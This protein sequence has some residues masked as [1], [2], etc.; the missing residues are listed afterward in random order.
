MENEKERKYMIDINSFNEI[1]YKNKSMVDITSLLQFINSNNYNKKLQIKDNDFI[2]EVKEQLVQLHNFFSNLKDIFSFFEDKNI[3]IKFK[4][5][6][7]RK[8]FYCLLCI[9][10]AIKNNNNEVNKGLTFKL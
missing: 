5:I 6:K 1:I 8:E 4:N 7:E 10:R 3:I 2:K 9:L